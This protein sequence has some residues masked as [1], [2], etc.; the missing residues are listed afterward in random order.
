MARVAPRPPAGLSIREKH[1]LKRAIRAHCSAAGVTLAERMRNTLA[2]DADAFG[3]LDAFLVW[4]AI[5]T[6]YPQ[7]HMT[8]PIADLYAWL[9]SRWTAD[10][11]KRDGK[12]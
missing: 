8:Q 6:E 5:G 1:L 11:R 3:G 2:V 12:K 10:V 4:D 7:K 9:A